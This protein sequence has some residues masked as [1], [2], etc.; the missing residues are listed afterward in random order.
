MTAGTDVL[1]RALNLSTKDRA[2]IAR[3]LILSLEP[4]EHDDDVD[5]AWESEIERRLGQV[6]RGEAKLLE[7]RESAERVQKALK[8]RRS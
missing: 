8:Q 5:A 6:D 1:N 2:E 7:W 3:Q 4:G